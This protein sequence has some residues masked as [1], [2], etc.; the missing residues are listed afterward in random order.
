[1]KLS[2]FEYFHGCDKKERR[3]REREREKDSGREREKEKER[4]SLKIECQR[5]RDLSS[6]L[7]AP[8]GHTSSSWSNALIALRRIRFENRDRDW[9]GGKEEMNQCK[10]NQT[11]RKFEKTFVTSPYIARKRSF[12]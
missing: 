11:P 7:A 6:I 5:E 3:K 8:S 2:R 9:G 12:N 4:K 10:K 1:V